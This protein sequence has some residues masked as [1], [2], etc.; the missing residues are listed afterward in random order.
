MKKFADFLINRRKI[1]FIAT[2]VLML[3]SAV[4]INFVTLNE[5]LT[6]YLPRNSNMRRGLEA[7]DREF[8][9]LQEGQQFLLMFEGLDDGQR[10]IVFNQL[11]ATDGVASVEYQP[12]S[13]HFN[14]DNYT[15]YIVT[16]RFDT[17]R[18]TERL[19]NS[20]ASS[21]PHTVHTYLPGV[22]GADYI[23]IML[24]IA[25]FIML[26]VLLIMCKSLFEPILLF[27]CLGIAIVINMGTNIIMPSVSDITFQV[28]TVL[29]LVL[30]IDYALILINRFRQEKIANGGKDNIEA[31]KKALAGCSKTILSVGAMTLI[32]LLALSFLSFRIGLD[33]GLVFAKGVFFNT[34]I[35]FTVLPSLLLWCDKIIAKLDK[36]NLFRRKKI[37]SVDN[38]D[39]EGLASPKLAPATFADN[40]DDSYR[41]AGSSVGVIALPKP[42]KFFS[43]MGN[44]ITKFRIP[45]LIV[46]VLFVIGVSI[47]QAFAVVNFSYVEDNHITRVFP[48]GDTIVI[49]YDNRDEGAIGGL[50]GHLMLDDEVR[51][52]NG[53]ATTIGMP[54]PAV[55]MATALEIDIALVGQVYAMNGQAVMTMYEFSIAVTNPIVLGILPDEASIHG[56]YALRQQMIATRSSFVGENLS[57]IIVSIAYELEGDEVRAFLHGIDD[58]IY[59]N[60]E[61]PVYIVGNSVFSYELSQTFYTEYIFITL[62]IIVVLFGI[63]IATL[64]K[65][66][67]PVFLVILIQSAIFALMTLMAI[68]GTPVMFLAILLVQA[69]VKASSL[70][71]SVLLVHLYQ[72]LRQTH[73]IRESIALALSKSFA[74]VLTAS[75]LMV[76]VTVL[77]SFVMAGMVSSILLALGL[78]TA[79][80]TF[81][82]I[83]VLP[84]FLVTFDKRITKKQSSKTKENKADIKQELL[85]EASV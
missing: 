63:L 53:Y 31:M 78:G 55:Q 83:T 64:R 7:M 59:S 20:I 76:S 67:A 73:S 71:R 82:I 19:I 65:I 58:I 72:E 41:G 40:S 27:V 11:R 28:A 30:A 80:A 16:S 68:I 21:S 25:I 47:G 81:I 2:L 51:S 12:N 48:T 43:G 6:Q 57:R 60:F 70:D 50:V 17:E 56:M 62:F 1:I 18:E 15:L 79:L 45:I 46:F 35:T 34:L 32:C 23:R 77:L 10:L 29:Q 61:H 26:I 36:A 9:D 8:V 22:P 85:V 39:N 24:P 44:F 37:Q 75:L 3:I 54:I 5:D 84:A 49:V 4:L 52:V 42:H 69:V 13:R 14:T 33:M 66:L 74:V 38:A